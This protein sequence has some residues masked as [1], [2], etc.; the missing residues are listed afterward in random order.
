MRDNYSNLAARL[1]LAP[2][3]QAAA[4]QGPAI[5]LL[6]VNRAAFVI[7]TGA[8][9]GAGD[10]GATLQESTDGSTGWADV[11]AASL[12]TN[13]PA[14]LAANASYKIGYFGYKRY[15]RLSL[16]KAGGTSLAAGAS[17]VLEGTAS[18]PVA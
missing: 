5:D 12:K 3:V 14:T 16:T 10:F 9:V 7:N 11:A 13:A 17:V 1:A 2:A 8:I 18:K 6:N 4:I 15:V